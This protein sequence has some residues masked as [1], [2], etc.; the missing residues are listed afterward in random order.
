MASKKTLTAAALEKLG[1]PRLAALLLELAEADAS[2]RR[3][4]RLELAVE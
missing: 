4:L 2:T 3:R 1:A